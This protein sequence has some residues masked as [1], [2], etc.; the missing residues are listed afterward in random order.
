MTGIG[1]MQVNLLLAWYQFDKVC[2]EKTDCDNL[3]HSENVVGGALAVV[4]S[5]AV[6]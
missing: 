3:K 4:V 1:Q 5:S 6:K 2:S